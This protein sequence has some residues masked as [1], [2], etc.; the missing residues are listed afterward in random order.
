MT[1]LHHC[2]CT[3][4]CKQLRHYNINLL[5]EAMSHLIVNNGGGKDAVLTFYTI[6]KFIMLRVTLNIS[7][8]QGGMNGSIVCILMTAKS[9]HHL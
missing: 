8:Y 2:T 6:I 7:S 1:S 9:Y 3:K 4:D 5:H